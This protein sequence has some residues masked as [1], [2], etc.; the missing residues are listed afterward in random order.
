VT[1]SRSLSLL[2]GFY[3]VSMWSIEVESRMTAM[4]Q[5]SGSTSISSSAQPVSMQETHVQWMATAVCFL[6]ITLNNL[7]APNAI[8]N[9]R[10][11]PQLGAMAALPHFVNLGQPWCKTC[12]R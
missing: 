7:R 8:V 5:V 4:T 6:I 9:L 10:G 12:I 11:K 2:R 3:C 1:S